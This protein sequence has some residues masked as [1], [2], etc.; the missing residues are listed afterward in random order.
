M[1]KP[2]IVVKSG[3]T[4]AGALAASSHTGSIAGVD[5]AAESLFRQC[6]MMRASSIEELF[7]YAVAFEN[8]PLPKGTRIAVLTNAGGPGIMTADAIEGVGLSMAR[9]TKETEKK[10]K[11]YL[12]HEASV[13]NPV[14]MIAGATPE[15]Y[16]KCL[17]ALIREKNVDAIIA[18][19]VPIVLKAEVETAQAIVDVG[20]FSS[21]PILACFL[22]KKEDSP[23]V[24]YLTEN[25]IPTYRFPESAVKA[26]L[27]LHNYGQWL[28]KDK[29]T[30]T[31]FKVDKKKADAQIRKAR[32]A[33]RKWLDQKEV[34]ALLQAY[35]FSF[36]KTFLAKS[37]D[38][39]VV[40][41]KKVNFPVVLKIDSPDVIHKW[42]VGGVALDLHNEREVRR[43]YKRILK[44]VL[45]K[46][47]DPKINGVRV[48]QMITKGKE[49]IIGMS[50]D[51]IY[52]PMIMY[53]MGGIYVETFKDVAFRLI[54]L[55]N[56][57]AKEM[58]DETKGAALLKGA[59]GEK[60]A[61]TKVLQEWL[62]RLAMLVTDNHEI[63]E[64]DMNP[65]MVMRKGDGCICVD[66]RVKLVQPD[67][68]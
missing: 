23:G 35:G 27:M 43:A 56:T 37:E 30:V 11:S 28:K 64:L 33:G 41:S 38:E 46:V 5:A 9:F 65:V 25:N 49:V 63:A 53:G 14:D 13:H 58:L 67:K 18:L 8:Q 32:N 22:G 60:P 21:K 17:K 36:S 34:R 51:P 15:M 31:K 42:D 1:K 40:L 50:L 45:S 6:G 16:R 68:E 3:R 47:K 4:K 26:L 55:T 24:R 19:N 54:P 61:D 48:E 29:G 44:N 57:D 10:L 39:A 62:Q 59:R 20:R 52:G 7:D 66:A 2:I 12:P